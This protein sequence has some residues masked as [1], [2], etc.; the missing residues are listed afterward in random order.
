MG[1]TCSRYREMRNV[2]KILVGKPEGKILPEIQSL[3][4][5]E[6]IRMDINERAYGV[7]TG[8]IWSRTRSSCEPNMV[9]NLWTP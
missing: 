9:T 5:E 4:W 3:T 8:L 1:G 2:Y 7:W 6:D